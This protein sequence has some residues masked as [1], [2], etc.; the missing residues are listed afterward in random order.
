MDF[1]LKLKDTEN[2]QTYIHYYEA[3]ILIWD[4]NII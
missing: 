1:T 4:K 2:T 3:V